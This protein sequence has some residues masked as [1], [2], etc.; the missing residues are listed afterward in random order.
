MK[1][2]FLNFLR[3]YWF[4]FLLSVIMVVG[5]SLS[6]CYADLY[7]IGSDMV[8]FDLGDLYLIYG[9]PLYSLIYGCLSYAILKKVWSSQLIL[10]AITFAY[11][12]TNGIDAL[13]WEGTYILSAYPVVFSL[14]GTSVVAFIYHIIKSIKGNNK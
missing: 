10:F 5:I 11:W 6:T 8:R 7:E 13:F 9:M 12:F 1:S 2:G 3:K 4:C 14:I